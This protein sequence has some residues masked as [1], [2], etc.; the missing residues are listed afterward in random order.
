MKKTTTNTFRFDL[1]L[2]L[3]ITGAMANLPVWIGAF[4][5]SDAQGEIS[6]W[7]HNVL[8]PFLAGISAIAMGLT[9]TGGLVYSIVRL[10][11]MKPTIEH[12]IRNKD[13]YKSIVNVRFYIA[14]GSVIILIVISPALLAPFVYMMVSGSES[15]F[16]VLGDPWSAVWS[17]GRVLAADLAMGAVALVTGVHLPANAATSA[18]AGGAMTATESGNGSK[19]ATQT[20][21]K[22]LQSAPDM[23]KCDVNGCGIS[24]RWPNGK[25]AHFKQYHRDLLI[26][27]GIP[28]GV[29]VSS[30][31]VAK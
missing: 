28:V 17:V 3:L 29:S 7:V 24:Y 22:K 19:G 6:L 27:K 30:K 21:K 11:S 9:V 15:L 13:E 12:K 18:Q 8:L 5:A 31:E 1:G 10:G 16:S 23:R 25:G 26:Q 4:M 14:W 20:A 2:A